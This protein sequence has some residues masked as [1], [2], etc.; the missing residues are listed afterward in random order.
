MSAIG[1]IEVNKISTSY[2]AK[3]SNGSKVVN[4]HDTR[5]VKDEESK[6]HVEYIRT[7]E[8][9]SFR[10]WGKTQD[11]EAIE[12]DFTIIYFKED[13]LYVSVPRDDS[14]DDPKSRRKTTPTMLINEN[15]QSFAKR[16][17]AIMLVKDVQEVSD[18][19]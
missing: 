3:N 7:E 2:K 4:P 16:L 1:L 15:S 6:V 9:K 17:G 12:G 18:Q 19:P 13:P 5:E 11:Q 10:P 14:R 8:I